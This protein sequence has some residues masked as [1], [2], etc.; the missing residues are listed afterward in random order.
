LDC[1]NAHGQKQSSQH[2]KPRRCIELVVDFA[3]VVVLMV[4]VVL[5]ALTMSV[6]L[7]GSSSTS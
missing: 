4:L 1:E 5:T 3:E 2:R 7:V 6:L